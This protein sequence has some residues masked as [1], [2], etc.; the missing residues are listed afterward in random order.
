MY[1]LQVNNSI[2]F[3]GWGLVNLPNSLPPDI[4]TSF[5]GTTPS[6]LFFQDQNPTNALATGDSQTFTLTVQ[7]NTAELRVTLVWTDPP[8]NPAAAIKLV[9]SLELV[10]TNMDN[11]TNPV[12]YYG[13]DIPADYIF[14]T[15]EGRTNTVVPD[16]INNVQNVI[17]P[18]YLG[19][20]YSIAIIGRSRERE[21]RLRADEHTT[22]Q[23]GRLR[24]QRRAGLR[25]GHQ[26]R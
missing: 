22:I 1:D 8:G 16:S 18:P 7:T 19:T 23:S 10:V 13:N 2:N 24:A 17:I 11:P 9:N 15:P 4:Q 3:T 26:Q 14:N 5:N 21:R 6:P 20:N 25:A 12:I